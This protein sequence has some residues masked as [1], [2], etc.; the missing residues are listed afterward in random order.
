MSQ[1]IENNYNFWSSFGIFSA[2]IGIL[3]KIWSHSYK[4]INSF[5]SCNFSIGFPVSSRDKSSPVLF[6]L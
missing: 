3:Q 1:F 2:H 4:E 6:V 5:D